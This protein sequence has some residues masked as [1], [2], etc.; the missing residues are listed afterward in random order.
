MTDADTDQNAGS[1][2]A[3]AASRSGSPGARPAAE[4]SADLAPPPDLAARARATGAIDAGAARIPDELTGPL[5][6][7]AVSMA[8]TEADGQPAGLSAGAAASA[9]GEGARGDTEAAPG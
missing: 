7:V 4:T 6:H 3:E 9:E 5:T 8:A 2:P 1:A